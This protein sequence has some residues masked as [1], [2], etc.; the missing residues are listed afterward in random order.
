MV[1]SWRVGVPPSGSPPKLLDQVRVV[2]R[3]RHYSR[4]TEEAYLGWMRRYI[5]FH[6]MQHPR[7][8]GEAEVTSYL[9]HLAVRE[10]VS[11]STQNQALNA[12][13]F[14]YRQVLGRDLG[15]LG[16]TV[17][18]RTPERLPVV[19]GRDEVRQVLGELP[20]VFGLIGLLLYGSGLRLLE[21]LE[22]RIKD[23]DV[24]RRQIIVR[25]GKGQKDRAVPLPSAVAMR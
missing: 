3:R 10:Q 8:L 17:R 14:L 23:V 2:L 25:R 19:L 15:G 22:L 21:C 11:A 4:R 16:D 24:A 9:T 13:L 7:D 6:G 5:A 20:G 18:A 1:L 12:L